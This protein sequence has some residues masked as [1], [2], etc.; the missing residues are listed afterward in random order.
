L[1][2]PIVLPKFRGWTVDLRL[3]EFRRV[4]KFGIEFVKFSSYKGDLLLGA[5]IKSLPKKKAIEVATTALSKHYPNFN[6]QVPKR[7]SRL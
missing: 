5:Y 2:T 1:E 4:T 6:A 3:K 7:S